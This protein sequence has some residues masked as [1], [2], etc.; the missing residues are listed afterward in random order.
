MRTGRPVKN[1]L[2][3]KFNHWE[4]LNFSYIC[5]HGDAKWACQ[6]DLCG[7]VYDVR[8]DALQSGRSTKCRK[9]AAKERAYGYAGS[10]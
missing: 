8:S 3:K 1:L 6:C 4:V 7:I 2:G 5:R 9:C 10:I